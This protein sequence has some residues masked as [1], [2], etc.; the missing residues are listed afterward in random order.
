MTPLRSYLGALVAQLA[1]SGVRDAVVAPGSRSTPL[2][3][4]L[5]E[6]PG[7]RVHMA[8]D[9]RSGGFFALGMA[10]ARQRPV[11]LVSTSGTAAANF[12][13]AVVE[14]FLSRVP[15]LVLTADRPRELRDVGAAQTIDQVHLYGRHVK[16]FQDLPTP[17]AGAPDRHAAQV[18]ARAVHYAAS[19]P[20]GPV[21]LNIP[22]REPLLP[23]EGPLPEVSMGPYFSPIAMPSPEAV[24]AARE[25]GHAARR[26]LLALGPESPALSADILQ[27]FDRAHWPIV[28]DP[29]AHTP[30]T[31]PG[32][33]TYDT[34][35][36]AW[37]DAPR[38]DLVV[39]LGA[40]LTSKAFQQWSREARMILVD[41]PQGF[42]DP[43]HHSA[44]LME[45][46][47]V[48][49]LK[50]LVFQDTVPEGSQTFYDQLHRYEAWASTRIRAVVEESPPTFEGRFYYHLSQLWTD[51]Q[52]PV[53]VA[54]SMPVR[55]LDTFYTRG[56]LN[57]FANRGANGIDG[58]VSTA[59]GIAQKHHDVLAILG[60]LAFHHD[61]TGLA[62]A[63]NHRL[64]AFFVVINNQ[65]G[66]IFSFLSQASLPHDTFEEL[67]G[68]PHAID[69]SG[70]AALYGAQYRRANDYS[71]FLRHFL[72][73][74]EAP[75]LRVL[76]WH[77]TPRQDT[78]DIH[79]RLYQKA[80]TGADHAPLK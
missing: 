14:A 8:L 56:S 55:D 61:M 73:L 52:K 74:R 41:W 75:G 11:V 68:T 12:L 21:H 27:A 60:D 22:V 77:T 24:A 63:L 28:I 26:P 30:R 50:A 59:L 25:W 35:L 34:F 15:L 67:F 18:A 38:P 65:G 32:L 76:D 70:V 44:L 71:T 46:D 45:G 80:E 62:L 20:Q 7:I 51:P 42:R 79:R 10:K 2:A 57:I 43:D 53:L 6:S 36:R 17:G 23:G 58:L 33:T 48:E 72:A 39:H 78:P 19:H 1:A 4:L 64:N 66:A 3:L 13:P 16:W 5:H 9:E 37:P 49:T 29:V 69:F 31:A 54:S 40:P 47:P